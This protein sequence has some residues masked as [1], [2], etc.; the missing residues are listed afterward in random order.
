MT[1]LFLLLA[2][3]FQAPAPP[4]LSPNP[5]RILNNRGQI[6]GSVNQR[7]NGVITQRDTQGRTVATATVRAGSVRIISQ[8]RKK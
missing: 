1:A 7:P 5:V 4:V 8:P 6:V 2:A 3:C